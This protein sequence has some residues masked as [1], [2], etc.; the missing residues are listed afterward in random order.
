MYYHRIVPCSL[1]HEPPAVYPPSK[2]EFLRPPKSNAAPEVARLPSSRLGLRSTST[3]NK[4]QRLDML[5]RRVSLLRHLP[6]MMKSAWAHV[7]RARSA[8]T[9]RA[10]SPSR[11]MYSIARDLSLFVPPSRGALRDLSEP[12]TRASSGT[13]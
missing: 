7:S 4:L 11:Y 8:G 13:C 1:R 6:V 9:G 10:A 3:A 5:D 2:Q 12:S